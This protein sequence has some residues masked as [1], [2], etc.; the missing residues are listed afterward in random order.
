MKYEITCGKCNNVY[1]KKSAPIGTFA[2]IFGQEPKVTTC[3]ECNHCGG[4]V[5]KK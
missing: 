1:T 4:Y 3:P 2:F 5:T